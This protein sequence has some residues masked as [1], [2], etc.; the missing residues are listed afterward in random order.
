MNASDP[1]ANAA[2]KSPDL[3][4]LHALMKARNFAAALT[5]GEALLGA[6]PEHRDARLLV[7]IAQRYLGRIPDALESLTA[8]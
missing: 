1:R 2:A 7:A 6:S 8:L 5:A 3:A 4:Q